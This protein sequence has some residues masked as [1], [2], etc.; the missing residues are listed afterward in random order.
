MQALQVDV[1]DDL[2]FWI[3]HWFSALHNVLS[4]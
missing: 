3:Y 4:M 2:I 1:L